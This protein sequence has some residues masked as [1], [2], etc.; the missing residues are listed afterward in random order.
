MGNADLKNDA[1]DVAIEKYNKSLGYKEGYYKAY[2]GLG[3]VYKKQENLPLMKENLDKSIAGAGDDTKLIGNAKDAAS[4]AFQ[5]AGALQLQ[6]SKYAAAVEN[7][8]ASQE[9][10]NTEPRT[11][12]YLAIAYNGL[13]K[14]DE[15]ITAANKAL[16]LQTDDKS[17]IYFELAKAQENKGDKA[18]ACT[19]Y[20]N[21]TAGN[22]VEA[23]KYQIT[24]VL[25]CQ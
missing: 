4:S 2:Y 21:V 5:K 10:D 14:W 12:Y 17:D 24:Q 9:Y 25:K 7:L 11:Y 20:K 18:N 3:L 6:S 15:A 22:N 8:L 13:S 19:N 16:E 1:L 23:A